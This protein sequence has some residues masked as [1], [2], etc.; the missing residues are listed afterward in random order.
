MHTLN[1]E[2]IFVQEW[3]DCLREGKKRETISMSTNRKSVKW[4]TEDLI[5][6]IN[7]H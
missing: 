4:V 7:I 6:L 3:E 5:F 2:K 1:S